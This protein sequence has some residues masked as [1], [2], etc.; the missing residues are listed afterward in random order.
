MV[1]RPVDRVRL[2]RKEIPFW[3]QEPLVSTTEILFSPLAKL[4]EYFPFSFLV[5]QVDAWQEKIQKIII[6]G[7]AISFSTSLSSDK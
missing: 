6:R 1:S 4:A 7:K 3:G 2:P 5:F